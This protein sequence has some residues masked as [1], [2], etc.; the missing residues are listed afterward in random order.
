[1]ADITAVFVNSQHGIQR[2]TQD[3]DK[4]FICNQY[5]ERLS[6]LNTENIKICG[7]ITKLEVIKM[8]FVCISAISAKYLSA[9]NLNF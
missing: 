9:E 6:I 1:M 8:Q 3:F 5:G 7:W 4:T 2:W